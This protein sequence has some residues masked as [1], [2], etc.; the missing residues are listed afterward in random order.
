M[1]VSTMNGNLEQGLVNAPKGAKVMV[2]DDSSV[3]RTNLEMILREAGYE[4]ITVSSGAEAIALAGKEAPALIF[5]DILMQDMD[6]FKTCRT[7]NR[8]PATANI[9]VVMVST[10]KN[11]ADKIWAAEQGAVGYIVKPFGQDDIVSTAQQ[12][13]A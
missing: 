6:G 3:D 9:P 11:K 13:L 4:V 1:A 10:K 2:V 7:L 8:D 12:Y 5:L